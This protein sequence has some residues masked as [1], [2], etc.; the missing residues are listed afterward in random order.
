MF[1]KDKSGLF[2]TTFKELIELDDELIKQSIVQ[3][4]EFD[5]F[6]SRTDSL[7]QMKKM[8]RAI[9]L[10]ATL[11]GFEGLKRIEDKVQLKVKF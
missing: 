4:D 2:A 7:E 1:D 10:S 6:Y 8:N 9:A 11:G 5:Q 3:I